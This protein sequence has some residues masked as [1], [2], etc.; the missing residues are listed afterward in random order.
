VKEGEAQAHE[1]VAV[2]SGDL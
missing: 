2:L 1:N